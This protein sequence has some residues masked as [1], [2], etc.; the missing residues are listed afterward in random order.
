[1]KSLFVFGLLLLA[2]KCLQP[3]PTGLQ[4]VSEAVQGLQMPAR[5]GGWARPDFG[6][7]GMAVHAARCAEPYPA[8]RSSAARG[9]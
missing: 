1:M 2:G 7:A 9:I 5:G 8:S 3:R 4:A 6:M